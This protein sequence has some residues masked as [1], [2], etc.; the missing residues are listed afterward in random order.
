M[1]NEFDHP[2]RE[3]CSG[4]QQ[5]WE[6]GNSDTINAFE[7]ERDRLQEQ[8]KIAVEALEN[9]GAFHLSEKE[10]RACGDDGFLSDA[11]IARQALKEI[12]GEEWSI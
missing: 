12:K 2:C 9:I 4:W 10:I 7:K 11:Q 8:L 1:K 3:T 5:G 6:R